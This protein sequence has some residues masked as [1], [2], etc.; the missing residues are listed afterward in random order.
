M[1]QLEHEMQCAFVSWTRWMEGQHPALKLGFAVANGSARHPA[2]AAK[3]KAEGVRPGVPDW[4][5]PIAN[6]ENIGLALEF[7]SPDGK[8]S[9]AQRD[10]INLMRA[11]R[12]LA[13]VCRSVDEAIAVTTQYLAK[14][15]PEQ[16]ESIVR[17]VHVT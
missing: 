5:L 8:V 7:K 12:W 11:G 13:V 16:R 9:D 14:L 17:R 3:L 4:L 10:Y 2:V 15:T 1:R 6:I